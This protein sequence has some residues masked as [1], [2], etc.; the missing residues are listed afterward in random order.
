SEAPAEAEEIEKPED[1]LE[2]E[3]AESSQQDKDSNQPEEGESSATEGLLPGYHADL[4][5]ITNESPKAT[6]VRE[7]QLFN[8]HL[9]KL[10][11]EGLLAKQPVETG[12]QMDNIV[13]ITEGANPGEW[14]AGSDQDQFRDGAVFMT[15]LELDDIEWKDP[16]KYDNVNWKRYFLIGLLSR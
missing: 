12:L 2:T 3:E 8:G 16:G 4:S 10:T 11:R 5:I 14:I 13:E 9:W 6:A 1:A 7:G 15:P